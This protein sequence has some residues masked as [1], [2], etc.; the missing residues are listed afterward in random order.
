[1]P[2]TVLDIVW[3][4][5]E[6]ELKGL[7]LKGGGES[8]IRSAGSMS[9]CLLD[10]K[11]GRKT[12]FREDV[13]SPTAST[14][15]IAILLAVATKV[16]AG[17][18][19]WEQRIKIP[20]VGKVGEGGPLGYFRYE[21]DLSLWDVAGLMIDHSDNDATN[22]C[23]D[24]A[25][26][27]FVNGLLS[28]LG[29][30]STRLQRHMIDWEAV[31]KGL[32]NF[33]TPGDLVKLLEKIYRRDGVSEGV[34]KDALE[35]LELPKRGPFALGLPPSVRR[36][37]KPGGLDHVSVDAGIVYLPEHDFCLAVMGAFLGGK[38]E[39]LVAE[40]VAAAYRYMAMLA[41]CTDLGRG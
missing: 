7:C 8:G 1:M 29:L 33:S 25:G 15:K 36:A 37:D 35:L 32:E 2:D 41:A 26:M 6:E 16:E 30:A 21:A 5:M 11:T 31:K 20:A 23:I 27:D 9:F 13:V 4:N 14:I 12:G 24:L 34:A 19:S 17:Q 3:R 22:I 38:P 39:E 18:L 28:G 10:L 40:V